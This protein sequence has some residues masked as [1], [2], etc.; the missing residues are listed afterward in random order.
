MKVI[1]K[2]YDIII[3]GGGLSGVCA[4]IASARHGSKTALIQNR[5]VLGGNASSEVRMHICGAANPKEARPNTRETGILEEILLENRKRNPNHSFS[6]LDIIL[7]EKTHF[8]DGLDLYLNTHMTDAYSEKN[9]IIKIKAHQL[10]TEKV[11]EFSG[12]LFVDATGDATLAHLVGAETI[13]G[14]E[15]KNVYGEKYAPDESDHYTMGSSL[16]FKAVDMGESVP[17]EKPFWANTYTN[18]DLAYRDH[19]EFSSGYWWIELGGGELDI[20]QDGEEIRDELLKAVYGVWDHIKNSGHHPAENFA[21]DWVGFLPGKRESR[22]VIGDYILKEQ[23]CF[24]G[25]RFDDA[26]AYGGW[27]MDIH[28]IEGLKT[29]LEP[30]QFF[31]LDDVY[32]IPYRCLYSKNID[33]LMIGGRAISTSHMAFGSTRVMATCAVIGQAIG[34]AGALA[35][36]KDIEPR[37]VMEHIKELQQQLLKDDCY[38]PGIE[39]T[40]ELDL[41]K[42]ASISDSSHLRNCEGKLVISGYAR[43]VDDSINGWISEEIGAEGEWVELKFEKSIKPKEIMIRFD[44]NLSKL[45]M[46]SLSHSAIEQ[47]TPGIPIELVKDYSIQLYDGDNDVYKEDITNNHLRNRKHIISQ[48]VKIDKIKIHVK[49]TNGDKHARIFEVRVYE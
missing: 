21:L 9:K 46:P 30:T 33:N 24:E 20:I 42:K 47:Q 14:R 36:E 5:P 41:A 40:D 39:N 34:T 38:I 32:T 43:T 37:N 3:V 29:R 18:E 2:E 4:A 49:A 31:F 8:Q 13:I 1:Q 15:G 6:T 45:I 48:E 44:S 10:T 12:K 22:R 25:R 35:I 19:Q 26:V 16:L 7:W 17:F 28:V 27:P 11:F 23:D